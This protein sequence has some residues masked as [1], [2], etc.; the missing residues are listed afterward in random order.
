MNRG[1]V[2]ERSLNASKLAI[3]D[4]VAT[5]G[6]MVLAPGVDAS[7]GGV[8]DNNVFHDDGNH[9]LVMALWGNAIAVKRDFSAGRSS[10]NHRVFSVTA[11]A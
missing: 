2:S 4:F 1:M 5:D 11:L 7:T 8:A 10:E 9:G 6:D 3:E